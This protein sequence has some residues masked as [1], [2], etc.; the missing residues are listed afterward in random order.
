MEAVAPKAAKAD[1]EAAAAAA[2][3]AERAAAATAAAPAKEEG[4]TSAPWSLASVMLSG[5][6]SMGRAVKV[7][8][9]VVERV[10]TEAQ[11]ALS[12]RRVR[13]PPPLTTCA[14]AC[15]CSPTLHSAP[16]GG[17]ARRVAGA[18]GLRC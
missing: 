4:G 1:K 8:G 10:N 11:A 13:P 6:Q 15:L 9:A 7:S 16:G 12:Q 17:V 3:A 14:F 5:I 18:P 2:T